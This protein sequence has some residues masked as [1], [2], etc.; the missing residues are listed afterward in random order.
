MTTNWIVKSDVGLIPVAVQLDV[1]PGVRCTVDGS[2]NIKRRDAHGIQQQLIGSG[3]AGAHR[4]AIHQGAIRGLMIAL[5]PVGYVT[6]HVVVEI[7]RLVIVR[8][9]RI[10]LGDNLLHHRLGSGHPFCSIFILDGSNRF[11]LF[12]SRSCRS[13]RAGS[14]SDE[15]VFCRKSEIV[16]KQFLYQ[17]NLHVCQRR[18]EI[19]PIV[20]HVIGIWVFYRF[21]ITIIRIHQG[22]AVGILRQQGA[23]I[24][25]RLRIGDF[26][27]H[28]LT[29]RR[30]SGCG[31]RTPIGLCRHRYRRHQHHQGQQGG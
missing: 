1:G 3:I 30:R 22:G 2:R 24:A 14:K 28:R 12:I 10:H 19:D 7:Q 20:I 11:I 13:L 4:M 25:L 8:P 27:R 29:R 15:A 6:N 21:L 17:T 5:L 31:R 18:L 26:L 9:G 23:A 16:V